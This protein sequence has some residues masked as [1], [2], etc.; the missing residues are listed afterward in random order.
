M[1][2]FVP[3]LLNRRPTPTT[4]TGT[5]EPPPAKKVRYEPPIGPERTYSGGYGSSGTNGG[6]K[7]VSTMG[8]TTGNTTGTTMKKSG[9]LAPR[10]P[11]LAVKNPRSK[12][13]AAATA[14]TQSS[15]NTGDGDGDDSYYN[16]LWR[17]KTQ[18]KHK[19]FDG[20]GVLVVSAGYGILQDSSGKD[21]GRSMISK[22]LEL[23]DI[24]SFG[25][26]DVEIDSLLSKSDFLAGRPFLAAKVA[27]VEAEEASPHFGAAGALATKGWKNPLLASTV[28]PKRT[29]S[30]QPTP[31]HD[32]TADNALVM[33]RPRIKVPANKHIVD[34]VVDPYVTQYLRPHQ[35]EGVEFLYQCVMG[36]RAFEGGNWQGAILADEMGLGKTL[37]TIALVWTLLKQNPIYE[38]QPVVKKALIVC[39]VTL[40][41]NWRREFRKWLDDVRIGV[42]VVDAKTNLRDFIVGKTYSVLIIGY[43]KLQKVA[44]EL[45]KANI[46]IVIADEGHRLKTEKNKAAE[47]IRSLNTPRRIILSG[48]PL[49]NDLHEFFTMVDF[50]NPGLLGSYSTFKKEF[51]NPILKSRQPGV[52]KKDIEKGKARSEELARITSQ[53]ILRRTSDILSSYLPPKKEYVIYCR[54]TAKQ[55]AVYH[56]IIDSSA[57]NK[58]LGSPDASLLLITL[59][60]KLCNTPGLLGPSSGKE[61]SANTAALL[62]N[63]SPSDLASCSANSSG[64]LRVLD[65]MLKVISTTTDEKIVLVS[66]YTSTLDVLQNLVS[67]RGLTWLRLDGSTPA[68]KRQQLVE[69]F[70]RTDNKAAFAFLLSAKAGGAG[71]NLIGASRLVLF[72]LDWNPATDLQAMARIH[73]DGQKRPVMIYRMLTTGCIDEKI[74]QRQIT[75]QGLADSVMDNKSSSSVFTQAELRDIFSLDE[76]TECQTHD[77]LECPCGG[78]G[79]I[80]DPPAPV[81]NSDD[82]ND[83][84]PEFPGIMKASQLTEEI[85]AG[86]SKKDTAKGLGAL[87]EYEHVAT[88]LLLR[89]AWVKDLVAEEEYREISVEDEVL[90]NVMTHTGREREVS[91]V[92]QKS[93]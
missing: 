88:K 29:N 30:K 23:G 46:D 61:Q 47:A 33:P 64:K 17:K 9:L 43:E 2:K 26:K 84:L 42:L 32:P 52:T 80:V 55:T 71:I 14:A 49:Q 56:S 75:K 25:G 89:D 92:F 82:E 13:T 87:M 90:M 51:E 37:Q 12:T 24:I 54:P 6:A 20:D 7:L 79:Y 44:S 50:V 73:R 66:N 58:C 77:L 3:P 69:K 60:K 28:M 21:L 91:F 11:L 68:D 93:F 62:A 63:A 76:E 40:I 48:T 67:S 38:D 4:A 36:M 22:K 41:N 8:N 74:F 16:V 27:A 15:Q 10:K 1:K 57:F 35:R 34:V 18:K 5:D 59:L 86:K 70:N 81:V 72:D 78:Q 19:T 31:R 39:P 83:D 45:K 65:R 85:I 53:F